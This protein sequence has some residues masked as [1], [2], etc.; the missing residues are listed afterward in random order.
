MFND[1]ATDPLAHCSA[2]LVGIFNV[3]YHVMFL[4]V[5]WKAI[6]AEGASTIFS[7]IGLKVVERE[8]QRMS[9]IIHRLLPENM[10][11]M[12]IN[13]VKHVPHNDLCGKTRIPT[14]SRTQTMQQCYSHACQTHSGMLF[15]TAW[16]IRVE[17]FLNAHGKCKVS[18]CTWQV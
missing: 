14:H 4:W 5:S 15:H 12:V 3:F 9:E 16:G 2:G 17:R 1:K 7:W 11:E 18:E 6:R 8:R 10:A 13:V